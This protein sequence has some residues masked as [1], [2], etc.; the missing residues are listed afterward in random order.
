[1]FTRTESPDYFC[2]FKKLD[3]KLAQV[4]LNRIEKNDWLISRL[5]VPSVYRNQRIATG[6][7]Q[8]LTAWADE[9][10]VTLIAEINPYGDLG[11]KELIEF[12]KKHGFEQVEKENSVLFIR[13]RRVADDQNSKSEFFP[14]IQKTR[15]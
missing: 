11:K 9:K 7:M 1:M 13:K 6:L 10:E 8:E 5:F 15:F 4:E 14:Y 2:I 3:H 12:L